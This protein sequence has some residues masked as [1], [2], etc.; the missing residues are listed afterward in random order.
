MAR[1]GCML[2]CAFHPELTDDDRIM[3]YFVKMVRAEI[4]A[5]NKR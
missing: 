1:Q 2:A 4:I 5:R 3:A